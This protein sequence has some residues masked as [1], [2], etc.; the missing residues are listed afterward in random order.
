MLQSRRGQNP[1]WLLRGGPWPDG[2]AAVAV[3]GGWLWPLS[4]G[5]QDPCSEGGDS[6]GG[7]RGA[8]VPEK[9]RVGAQVPP[10]RGSAEMEAAQLPRA[11]SLFSA[12]FQGL[13]HFPK[14]GSFF[15]LPARGALGGRVGV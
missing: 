4:W 2:P 5:G 1:L 7:G 10:R 6:A 11:L 9:G 15:L 13:S 14:L 8:G 3:S 12:R